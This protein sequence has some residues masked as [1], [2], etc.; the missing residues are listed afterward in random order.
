MTI[1]RPFV[2]PEGERTGGHLRLNAKP[3]PLHILR[4]PVGDHVATWSCGCR[5]DRE[6][7]DMNEPGR[8]V[9]LHDPNWAG[10]PRP[11]RETP[12]FWEIR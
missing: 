10:E 4:G 1:K 2:A 7:R 9:F 3:A 12:E 8:D 11:M 6:A 5:P